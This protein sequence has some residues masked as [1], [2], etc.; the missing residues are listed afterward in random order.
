MFSGETRGKGIRV[1]IK[2]KVLP[3]HKQMFL[4][5]EQTGCNISRFLFMAANVMLTRQLLTAIK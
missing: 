3:S 4:F 1:Y 2:I 5:E